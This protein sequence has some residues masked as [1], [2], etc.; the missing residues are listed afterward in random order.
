VRT[1]LRTGRLRACKEH[2]TWSIPQAELNAIL[3]AEVRSADRESVRT[4]S[5]ARPDPRTTKPQQNRPHSPSLEAQVDRA[6]VRV[7]APS[8]N[9]RSADSA[10][11]DQ[12]HTQIV[13]RDRRLEDKD[14]RI[15][16]IKSGFERQLNEKDQRL[17]E[18]DQRI[19]DI[20]E[21]RE[22]DRRFFNEMF[23][24]ANRLIQSLEHQVAQLEAPRPRAQASVLEVAP[25]PA[26]EQGRER[27]AAPGQ[28]PG[29]TADDADGD[30]PT[31]PW[32]RPW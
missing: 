8:E 2:G 13:D 4:K 31:R 12:L 15:A 20:K 25:E 10:L 27:P 1:W 5:T 19:A 6:S 17:N 18:K 22:K 32:W 9:A 30:E 21:E 7:S 16:E 11:L 28:A 29:S 3:L 14:L 24:S 26:Q 23:T